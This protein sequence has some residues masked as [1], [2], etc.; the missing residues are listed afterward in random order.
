M[1]PKLRKFVDQLPMIEA[2]KPFQKN[3]NGSYYEMR[4][5]E[6][7]A[8][9]H[10]D[11]RPTRLWG[12]NSQFPGPLID[13]EQ[14][15]AIQVKWANDL[16]PRHILPVDRSIHDVGRQPEVR[17]VTH[18]HGGETKSS[19][20]GYPEAWYTNG[21]K[22]VG[23]FFEREVYEYSN[24]QRPMTLWYHDHAMGLTRL[25]VY[26]GLAGMYI[27]RGKEEK[28][29]HLPEGKYEIPLMIVDR[30]FNGDGSLSYP[31]QPEQ[32][33]N[34]P[35]LPDPS[36]QPFFNG[37]TNLVNG[38]VWPYLEVEPRKYRFRILNA[39][40]SRAYQ[41]YLDS[42]ESF[43]QIGSDGG[44][45]QKTEKMGT[46]AI[47]P[48]ERVDVIIDFSKF[49]GETI[50]LKNDLG[51]NADPEDETHDVMQ[52]R[53][54]LPLSSEDKSRIPR[55]L[56]PIPSLKNNNITTIRNLKLT[57]TTDQYGRPI[58]LLDNKRWVDPVSEKPMLGST[59][60][61][62]FMNI[63]DFPHPMHIHLIQ[64]QVLDRRPFD[65]DWYNETGQIKFT[66]PAAAPEPNER[67]WK[68]TVTAPS[69]EFTRVI[70]KFAPH[71]GRYVWHCHI[72]EHEEYDMM[73]PFDVIDPDEEK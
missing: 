26:A 69:G 43:Y 30:S 56:S 7:R 49:E 34:M 54:T 10:K 23:P 72:L 68:D 45:M 35:E 59:E 24:K 21:F 71:T 40:N 18:L 19:S 12:Y 65:L 70:V 39:A 14:G 2:A 13:V 46:L 3:K 25:N 66:A 4:M 67:G 62:S 63:T 61:W 15:E 5:R 17:T 31:R 50:H 44:L 51:E 42:G 52:F 55:N 8:K 20:D 29:L 6:F 28:A 22:E 9:L 32:D 47:D 58:L 16:P 36:I 53:V 27:I 38:K 11:L 60:I 64:F 33:P 73:R 57:S 1:S 48:A 37:D 41:L